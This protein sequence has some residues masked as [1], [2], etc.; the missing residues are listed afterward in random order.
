MGFRSWWLALE[1]EALA[2]T[3]ICE[4]LSQARG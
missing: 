3:Q 4:G 2:D 1:P